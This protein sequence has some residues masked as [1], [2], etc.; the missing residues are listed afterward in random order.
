MAIQAMLPFLEAAKAGT[1]LGMGTQ[2][3][4]QGLSIAGQA[5]AGAGIFNTLASS[6]K[7]LP[8]FAKGLN[9]GGLSGMAGSPGATKS[10]VDAL[11]GSPKGLA[12]FGKGISSLGQVAGLMIGGE[13]GRKVA[14][15]AGMFGLVAGMAPDIANVVESFTD[16]NTGTEVAGGATNMEGLAGNDLKIFNY[17]PT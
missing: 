12:A 3:A 8:S 13:K 1:A 14:Q 4:A 15:S 6:A 7:S 11:F 16:P 17:S 9:I 10:F 5:G 2:A